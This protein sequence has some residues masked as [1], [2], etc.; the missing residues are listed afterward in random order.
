M[1]SCSVRLR[2]GKLGGLL[3]VAVL[4]CSL[5]LAAPAAADPSPSPMPRASATARP[6]PTVAGVQQNNGATGAVSPI[7]E[8][9]GS[10]QQP[11]SAVNG[12]QTQP[13]PA[14][15]SLPST[16]TDGSPAMPLAALGIAI[17]GLGVVLLR[18][19]RTPG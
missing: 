6:S 12:V 16:S 8:P 19:S 4:A 7:V 11:P 14:P 10:I 9:G 17:A 18:R 2:M 13:A 5:A 15:R 3:V 1:R